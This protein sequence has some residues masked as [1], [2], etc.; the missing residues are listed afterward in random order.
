MQTYRKTVYSKRNE[1]L[2]TPGEKKHKILMKFD[3]TFKQCTTVL[4]LSNIYY[5]K[6]IQSE[7]KKS[8][9]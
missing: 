6:K 9:K 1:C 4:I 2:L 8:E 3:H 5:S 7:I